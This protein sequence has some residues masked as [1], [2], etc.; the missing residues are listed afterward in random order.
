MVYAL[1]AVAVLSPLLRPGYVLTLDMVFAPDEDFSDYI[2]GMSEGWVTAAAPFLWLQQ[3]FTHLLPGWVF[4]KIILCLILFLSGWGGHRM[5][6]GNGIGSYFAG[7]FYAVNPFTYTRFMAGQ[8]GVLWAYALTPFAVMAF[9]EFLETREGRS[10]PKLVILTTLVGLLQIHGLFLLLLV[11][12][13]LTVVKL[14]QLRR[15]REQALRVCKL[16]L[17]AG[18]AFTAINA[19]WIIPA[20][21]ADDT[22]LNHVDTADMAFFAP[23]TESGLGTAFDVASLHGFWR[24]GYTYARDSIPVWWLIYGGILFLAIYGFS[25]G[26]ADQ[27]KKWI[28]VAISVAGVVSFILGLGASSSFGNGL[29]TWLWDHVMP[30]R[31]FRDSHKFIGILCLAYAYLAGLGVSALAK[32]IRMRKHQFQKEITPL[33]G[34][35]MVCVPLIY[36]FPMFG[37]SGNLGTTDYP[38]QWSEVN[39]YLNDDEEDFSVLVLPWHRYM[40]FDWL[41]NEDKRLNNPARS[42]FDKPVV[43]GDNIEIPGV[44]TQSTNPVSAYIEFLLG[45]KDV[46]N[47][48]GELVAP[49]NAKYVLLMKE[50]DFEAYGFL[51]G[52]KDLETALENERLIL[53]KNRH[54]TARSYSVS[55]L[56]CVNGWEDVFRLSQSQDIME[57]LYL[58]GGEAPVSSQQGAEKRAVSKK[59]DAKF[60]VD[61]TA[62]PYTVFVVPQNVNPR[63]W[64]YNGSDSLQNLGFMPAFISD[65]DGGNIVYQRFYSVYLPA[66]G[67]SGIAV[68]GLLLWYLVQRRN[69]LSKNACRK[70]NTEST[71]TQEGG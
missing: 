16:V 18:M 1:L 65:E 39:A 52:Q 13:V 43:Q 50:A 46:I 14:Y 7:I 53:F 20:W 37:F 61:G 49:L 51:R 41:P 26:P 34:V 19:Y 57:H 35:G 9:I 47:N 62:Q 60:V 64:Q 66:Y 69:R 58:F 17:M 32:E 6:P 31:A 10:I 22:L 27:Q 45:K 56:V 2:Y 28:A 48:F 44:Y 30:L 25:K 21:S 40:D 71:A 4:Q 3:G 63:H 33:V 38:P 24:E 54:F 11:Y 8:W 12:L 68:T 5:I 59:T 23:K 36:T 42:F 67:V 15:D 29:F 55:D 70:S